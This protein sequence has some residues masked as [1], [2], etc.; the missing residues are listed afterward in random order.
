MVRRLVIITILLLP[1]PIWHF[2][3][4]RPQITMFDVGQGLSVLVEDETGWQLLFDGGPDNSVLAKLGESLAPTDTY[5]D[6][7][8]VSH[9]HRDHYVG[10]IEVLRRYRVGELW[11]TKTNNK[12]PAWQELLAVAQEKQV[13]L[14]EIK[15]GMTRYLTSSRVIRVYHPPARPHGSET[16]DYDAV[17]TV[18]RLITAD[19]PLGPPE[20]KTDLVLT[21]D[22]E[23]RHEQYIGRCQISRVLACPT[24][25]AVLQA[26]HH[27][28]KTSTSE[29]W[30]KL[31]Q[32][33]L[34]L[35]SV[36][37]G[38]TYGHPHQ[39][40]LERL[41]Q[42]KINYRRTDLNGDTKILL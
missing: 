11:I 7:V 24:T 9:Q 22:A 8:V 15:E 31:L 14:L 29:E 4:A 34:V 10:L 25:G 5:L 1:F 40:V 2:G 35:I 21:G 33:S 30:L 19:S 26:G 28:S 37:E 36:G 41:E 3:Q 32:P 38:N 20:F 12:D 16:H 23:A 13:P 18:E 17:L 6:V 27:G 42:L 39:E